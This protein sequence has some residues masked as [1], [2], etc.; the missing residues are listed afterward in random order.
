[1]AESKQDVIVK[2]KPLRLDGRL[3]VC[4]RCAELMD[5][6]PGFR[7]ECKH[8]GHTEGAGEFIRRGDS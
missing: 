1:M 3:L 5:P 6:M 8:C 7:L 2:D 4:P